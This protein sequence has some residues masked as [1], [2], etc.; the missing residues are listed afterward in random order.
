MSNGKKITRPGG[1][2]DRTTSLPVTTGLSSEL[3]P[4]TNLPVEDDYPHVALPNGDWDMNTILREQVPLD[5]HTNRYDRPTI[6]PG[7]VYEND[8]ID[9]DVKDYSDINR[10]LARN[11]GTWGYIGGFLT[12]G[13]V[14]EIAGGI[15]EGIGSMMDAL[16]GDLRDDFSHPV[17]GAGHWLREKAKEWAPI[18]QAP[19]S[20]GWNPGD[21][22]WWAQNGVS[23]LSSISMMVPA[24]GLTRGVSLAGN[25]A[26][27][28]N[29]ATKDQDVLML[30]IMN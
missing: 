27:R 13:V 19:S 22:G 17:A 4:T 2:L 15:I 18:Y 21:P 5:F 8:D 10:Q 16:D 3:N 11:Q 1:G 20:G 28:A 12:Q 7:N 9:W 30:M 6:F 29:A 23:V 26:R 25:L 14:G 24:Y